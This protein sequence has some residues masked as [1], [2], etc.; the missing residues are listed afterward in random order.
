ML[1]VKQ[2][3]EF[4]ETKADDEEVKVTLTDYKTVIDIRP[5][6]KSEIVDAPTEPSIAENVKDEEPKAE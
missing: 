5:A 6:P 3:R 1:T 2:L 4:L